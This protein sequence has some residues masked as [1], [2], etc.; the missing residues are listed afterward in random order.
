[1]GSIKIYNK[2]MS[3]FFSNGIGDVPTRVE[4]YPDGD[5]PKGEFLGHFTSKD[6]KV[7]L[8]AYDCDDT[9][10]YAFKKGRWFVYRIKDAHLWIRYFDDSTHA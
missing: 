4:I 8:S 5:T 3:A 1:M 9:P 6:G 10:I 2:G 7:Y